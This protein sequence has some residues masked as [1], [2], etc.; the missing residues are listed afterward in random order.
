MGNNL[1]K[2]RSLY[3]V[4]TRESPNAFTSVYSPQAMDEDEVTQS[5]MGHRTTT[6]SVMGIPLLASS[7]NQ[8]QSSPIEIKR[9]E[10]KK[11]SK[12]RF[13]GNEKKKTTEDLKYILEIRREM[14]AAS[15]AEYQGKM[16]PTWEEPYR[17]RKAY[18]DRAYK[19][20]ML[21]GEAI[22]RT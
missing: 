3:S 7:T 17:V 14:A 8:K 1:Q 21:S 11:T 22:D 5:T 6:M 4:R 18:G 12:L 2:A 9:R 15:K 10:N 20:E 13:Q 16:G 19:L